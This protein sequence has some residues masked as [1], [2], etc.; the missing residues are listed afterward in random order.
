LLLD[1]L[2]LGPQQWLNA[3]LDRHSADS[4]AQLRASLLEAYQVQLADMY[5]TISEMSE[6]Q[7]PAE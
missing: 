5:M 1:C 4:L 7:A 3:L 2:D 6:A